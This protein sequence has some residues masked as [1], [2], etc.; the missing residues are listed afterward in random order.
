MNIAQ[1][2]ALNGVGAP[3][4]YL[5]HA[6][7][8]EVRHHEH[9][10]AELVS[11]EIRE[12]AIIPDKTTGNGEKTIVGMGKRRV[13]SETSVRGVVPIFEALAMHCIRLWQYFS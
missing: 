2:I 12:H 6:I 9:E 4:T 10:I 3:Y 11:C 7:E 8:K 5:E 13:S 1:P